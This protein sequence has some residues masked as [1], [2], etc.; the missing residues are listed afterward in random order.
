MQLDFSYSRRLVVG[1]YKKTNSIFWERYR[2]IFFL[3]S[4]NCLDG[5][6]Q[7][8]LTLFALADC[9][10]VIMLFLSEIA[11]AYIFIFGYSKVVNVFSFLLV[12]CFLFYYFVFVLILVC[13]YYSS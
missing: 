2:T 1:I 9:F 7:S 11:N 8:N 13:S 6:L 5:R 10:K 12:S 4:S 3:H